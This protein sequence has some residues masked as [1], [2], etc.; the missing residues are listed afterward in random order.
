MEDTI[1]VGTVDGVVG[2]ETR[3]FAC[4]E[5]MLVRNGT[6]VVDRLSLTS[7]MKERFGARGKHTETIVSKRLV[8]RTD[9]NASTADY[10]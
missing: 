9:I 6:M 2:V 10:R 7:G 3:M 5:S 8:I 4:L 1:G